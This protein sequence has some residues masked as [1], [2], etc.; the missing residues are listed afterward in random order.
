MFNKNNASTDLKKAVYR[1][2]V[3]GNWKW[4]PLNYGTANEA[5]ARIVD[6]KGKEYTIQGWEFD[7]VGDLTWEDVKNL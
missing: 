5:A 6:G 1:Q 2:G 7:W 3:R 4:E